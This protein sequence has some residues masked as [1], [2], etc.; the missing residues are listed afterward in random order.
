MGNRTHHTPVSTPFHGFEDAGKPNQTSGRLRTEGRLG[1]GGVA[2]ESLNAQALPCAV[3]RS[4]RRVKP[5]GGG[6]RKKCCQAAATI[7]LRL[8]RPRPTAC[9]AGWLKTWAREGRREGPLA[10]VWNWSLHEN[11]T[12]C[13]SAILGQRYQPPPD[14]TIRAI[15]IKAG[16][17]AHR[18]AAGQGGWCRPVRILSS[19]SVRRARLLRASCLQR[20]SCLRPDKSTNRRPT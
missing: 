8:R 17:P 12:C 15:R 2:G 5:W 10:L 3:C 19:I 20:G 18:P 13:F 7:N 4:S 16:R 6:P 11:T 9:L 1:G 14:P